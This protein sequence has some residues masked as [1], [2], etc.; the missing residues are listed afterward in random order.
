MI[1]LGDVFWFFP[2]D[3]IEMR[4]NTSHL[5]NKRIIER[6]IAFLFWEIYAYM[7]DQY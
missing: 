6:D 4:S 7:L 2:A 3:V 1:V 5:V